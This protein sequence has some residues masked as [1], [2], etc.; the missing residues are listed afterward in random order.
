MGRRRRMGARDRERRRGGAGAIL[1]TEKLHAVGQ[2]PRGPHRGARGTHQRPPR[3]AQLLHRL[4]PRRR[5]HH[6][7]QHLARHGHQLLGSP[8]RLPLRGASTGGTGRTPL[9]QRQLDTGRSGLSFRIQGGQ[10]IRL[11]GQ[12]RQLHRQGTA[13]GPERILWQGVPQFLPPRH[14]ER[15]ASEQGREGR[16]VH[17]RTGLHA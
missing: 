7:A 16:R 13:R 14:G 6:T 12:A 8:G 11:R 2:R 17:R 3:A 15:R 9:Q 1:D 4:P 5:G 10:Q